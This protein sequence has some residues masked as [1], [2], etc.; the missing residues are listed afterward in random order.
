MA[1]IP[2][3]VC[4]CLCVYL[5]THITYVYIYTYIYVYR[6]PKW[7]SGQESTCQCKRCK[8][9][10]FNPCIRKILWNSKWQPAPVFSP[11]KF[12]GQRSLGGY[13]L[14]GCKKLNTTEKLSTHAHAYTHAYTFKK[15][16]SWHLVPPLHG[17]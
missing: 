10:R 12:Q 9:Y 3:Y 6:L 7:C 14:W 15:L 5:H 17:K 16:R 2:L 13:S 8:R 1:N 4:V 11:E